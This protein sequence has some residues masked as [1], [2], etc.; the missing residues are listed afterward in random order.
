MGSGIGLAAREK[1]DQRASEREPL[2]A[3]LS[4]SK[5]GGLQRRVCSSGEHWQAAL[6]HLIVGIGKIIAKMIY[7]ICQKYASKIIIS[8]KGI[9]TW[10]GRSIAASCSRSLESASSASPPDQQ[11]SPAPVLFE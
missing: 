1:N 11:C 7:L 4:E 10:A 6:A 3:A 5:P 9:H 8:A 2:C